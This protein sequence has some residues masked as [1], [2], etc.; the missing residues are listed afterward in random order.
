MHYIGRVESS[1]VECQVPAAEQQISK[2]VV[3][4]IAMAIAIVYNSILKY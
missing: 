3:M 4:A 2:A 1:R